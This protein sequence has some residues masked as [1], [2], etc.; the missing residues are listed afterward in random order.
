MIICKSTFD[1]SRVLARITNKRDIRPQKVSF[2][3][4]FT[5]SSELGQRLG[6]RGYIVLNQQMIILYIY[7][8]YM[9]SMFYEKHDLSRY[10]HDEYNNINTIARE[11]GTR[12]SRGSPMRRRRRRSSAIIEIDGRTEQSTGVVQRYITQPW[13]TTTSDD[14]YTRMRAS[15]PASA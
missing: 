14:R 15:G 2:R 13:Y 4:I 9:G 5:V 10:A 7:I 1:R 6:T 12:C 11:C 8:V 3:L